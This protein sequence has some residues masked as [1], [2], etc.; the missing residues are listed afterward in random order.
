MVERV[1]IQ[2]GRLQKGKE[3]LYGM[4][5]ILGVSSDSCTVLWIY[6]KYYIVYFN[7]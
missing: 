6:K 7:V 4:M 1:W 2:C 3:F 5:K